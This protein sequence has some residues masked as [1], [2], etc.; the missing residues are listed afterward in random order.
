GD[1]SL[2][3]MI[4]DTKNGVYITRF[5]YF[6]AIR[7]DKAV[8][9]GLTRDACWYIEDGEIVHPMKVMR[10]TDSVM[11]VMSNIDMIGNRDTVQTFKQATIP[12]LKVAKLKFTVQSQF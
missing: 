11:D 8:I 7:R 10:F 5:W 2:E 6:R 3:E 1:A 12:I 9:T 4:A